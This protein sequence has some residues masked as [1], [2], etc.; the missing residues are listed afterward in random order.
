MSSDHPQ[1][2]GAPNVPPAASEGKPAAAT[3]ASDAARRS[4]ELWA[5]IASGAVLAVFAL[6]MTWFDTWTFALLVALVAAAMSWEWRRVVGGTGLDTA[7]WVQAASALAAVGLTASGYAAM[8]AV[9]L[10]LGAIV[11]LPLRAGS[12]ARLSALGVLYVGLPAVALVWLRGGGKPYGLQAILFLFLVVWTTDIAAFFFGRSIGG[13]K[14][15]PR[16]SPGKTWSGFIGGVGTA[17]LAAAVFAHLV[18]GT[19]AVRLGL[20]GLALA[21]I[22]QAGDLA[23]SALKRTFNVKDSSGLIPGHGGFMDRMD[24]IVPV[25][26][27]AALASLVIDWRE[28]AKALLLGP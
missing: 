20:G 27:V 14:L 28:P 19:G 26:V 3:A 4:R 22:A 7:F 11:V 8:G 25:A 24:S 16:V 18:L 1:G 5:R 21:L 10:A 12:G 6:A 23:E 9:V 13:P 15:W 17:A 2:A